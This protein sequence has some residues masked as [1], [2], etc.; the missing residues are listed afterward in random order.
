MQAPPLS[1]SN[2]RPLRL[3][4]LS[5]LEM[6][7]LLRLSLTLGAL[8]ASASCHLIDSGLARR[9]DHSTT[10]GELWSSTTGLRGLHRRALSLDLNEA[11]TH[12]IDLNEMPDSDGEPGHHAEGASLHTG[13][14]ASPRQPQRHLSR[15]VTPTSAREPVGEPSS[16]WMAWGRR[17]SRTSG[18][19]LSSTTAMPK[20]INSGVSSSSH[21]VFKKAHEQNAPMEKTR[22]LYDDRWRQKK[23]LLGYKWNENFRDKDR[24]MNLEEVVASLNNE[25]Y[26]PVTRKKSKAEIKARTLEKKKLLGYRRKEKLRD[27]HK[28]RAF[29]LEKI[30]QRRGLDPFV[31]K[32][33]VP[34]ARPRKTAKDWEGKPLDSN[35]DSVRNVAVRHEAAGDSQRKAWNAI[36]D[37]IL[38][39]PGKQTRAGSSLRR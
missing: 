30:R 9:T 33:S 37:S 31:P 24:E 14:P 23:K 5:S 15:P 34:S 17:K 10:T 3:P 26:I 16:T 19:F 28:T 1:V 2:S 6:V 8:T 29:K 7:G 18:G 27:E 39:R 32:P 20:H 38:A 35:S 13:G 22:S 12:H 21:A 25:Q 11:P 4:P 36:A